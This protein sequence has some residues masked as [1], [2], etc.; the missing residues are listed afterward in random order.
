MTPVDLRNLLI[1]SRFEDPVSCGRKRRDPVTG[2]GNPET[3]TAL[4]RAS[5]RHA[6]CHLGPAAEADFRGVEASK[7]FGEPGLSDEDT[8][9]SGDPD[10]L[11]EDL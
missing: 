3:Q 5:S 8:C 2:H 1:D 9:E 10:A 4:D 6:N 11:D 7:E